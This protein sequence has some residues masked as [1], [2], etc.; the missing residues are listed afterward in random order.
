MTELVSY[1]LND[2]IAV[3]T[4]D[5]G[6]ANVLS[7]TMIDQ[8][9]AAF[10]KAQADKAIVVFTGRVPTEDNK[11]I[12]S[13]GFDLKVMMQGPLAA[14]TLTC[15]GSRLALRML[16]FP[17]PIITVATG[18][19]IAMGGFLLLASDYRIGMDEGSKTGL[20]ETLI[21]M[22]MHHFGIEL[23]RERISKRHL[24]RSMICAEIFAPQEAVHA[25]FLDLLVPADELMDTAMFAAK[26]MKALSM[27]AFAGTKLKS[28]KAFLETLENAIAED[29]KMADD[30]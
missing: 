18:H 12:F 25:G 8:L 9:N 21:G 17:T 10:D 4:M 26:Q 20:N 22:T 6:K 27:N 30:L 13:G 19:A 7:P 5:D 15:S 28:R 29:E 16:R 23:A 24:T 14:L 11:P 2:G 3:I 1:T